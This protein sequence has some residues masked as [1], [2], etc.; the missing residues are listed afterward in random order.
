MLLFMHVR[1]ERGLF[2]GHTTP[3]MLPK[4]HMIS[5]G[6]HHTTGAVSLQ[7]SKGLKEGAVLVRPVH[8]AA[9]PADARVSGHA[10]RAGSCGIA[11]PRRPAH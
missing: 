1:H 2:L 7:A 4:R 11:L 6:T 5:G 8:D 3:C 10:A 9:G